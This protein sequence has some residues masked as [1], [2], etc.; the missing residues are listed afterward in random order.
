MKKIKI[1]AAVLTFLAAGLVFHANRAENAQV[2][3][4]TDESSTTWMCAACN[5]VYRLSAAEAEREAIRAGGPS[6]LICPACQAKKAF[7]AAECLTCK[8]LYFSADVPGSA[9]RCLRCYPR[10]K[11]EMEEAASPNR[12]KKEPPPPSA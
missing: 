10:T 4:D 6:P 2:L 8:M 3:P 1:A 9:G 11:E 5:K 12:P 7:R